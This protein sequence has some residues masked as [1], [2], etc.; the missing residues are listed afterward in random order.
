MT[1]LFNHL[2]CHISPKV[3]KTVYQKNVGS[4]GYT[5][6]QGFYVYRN[7]EAYCKINMVQTYKKEEPNASS[8]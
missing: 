8:C 3:S 4:E 1:L 7:K 2:Y 6:N 5:E